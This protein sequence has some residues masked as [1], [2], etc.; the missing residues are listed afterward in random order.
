MTL[1]DSGLCKMLLLHLLQV[2]C[3]FTATDAAA[4]HYKAVQRLYS[5][6]CCHCLGRLH[7]VPAPHVVSACLP[8]GD[9][10][11]AAWST[12]EVRAAASATCASLAPGRVPGF[13][14]LQSHARIGLG[15]NKHAHVWASACAHRECHF[16]SGLQVSHSISVTHSTMVLK[17]GARK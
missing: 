11:A 2:Q 15:T 14:G 8:F 9:L 12:T 1:I 5:C 6:R 4:M 3:S 7:M 10:L 16:S 13:I 17:H